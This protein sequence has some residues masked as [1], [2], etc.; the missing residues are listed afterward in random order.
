MALSEESATIGYLNFEKFG[1]IDELFLG[2]Y[3]ISAGSEEGI[4]ITN[5]SASS[6][7]MYTIDVVAKGGSTSIKRG[8]S[9]RFEF[10]ARTP[11]EYMLDEACDKFF[12]KKVG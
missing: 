4:A 8:T 1:M 7:E 12:W 9:I 3:A 6:G 5:I 2:I 10:E 11:K